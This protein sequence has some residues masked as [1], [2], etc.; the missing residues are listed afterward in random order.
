MAQL[1]ESV[2]F[3]FW[4]RIHVSQSWCLQSLWVF[5]TLIFL[6]FFV[7]LG[8]L[9]K[10]RRCAHMGLELLQ[11]TTILEY[12]SW[13]FSLGGW[14]LESK[15]HHKHTSV[16]CLFTI[17]QWLIPKSYG[18]SSFVS[19]S[20]SEASRCELSAFWSLGVVADFFLGRCTQ[21][22]AKEEFIPSINKRFSVFRM[23]RDE[24]G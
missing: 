9:F 13:A 19:V 23:I 14:S 17:C 3:K 18:T 24:F 5:I 16:R 21:Q 11:F 1:V 15:K 4:N 7:F 20:D 12:T 8:L 22:R 2:T 10:V 6:L